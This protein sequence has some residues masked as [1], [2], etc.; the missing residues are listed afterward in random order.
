MLH[1]ILQRLTPG[2]CL[3]HELQHDKTN[4]TCVPSKLR[5]TQSDQ[6]LLYAQWVARDPNFF[7]WAAKTAQTGQMPRLILIF[8]GHIGRFVGSVV[9]WLICG[10]PSE[11]VSSSVPS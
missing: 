9:L 11:F 10:A 8:A 5:S 6:S 4:M 7:M 2:L 1:L 3:I